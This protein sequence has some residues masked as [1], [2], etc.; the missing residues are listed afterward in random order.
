KISID[1]ASDFLNLNPDSSYN[2]DT[3]AEIN[4]EGCSENL[5]YSVS[6]TIEMEDP[7][8]HGN[9]ILSNN[10]ITGEARA[11]DY[12][13]YLSACISDDN[14]VVFPFT[15]KASIPNIDGNDVELFTDHYEVNGVSYTD[16][17]YY[18]F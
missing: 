8:I 13:E 2:L 12:T 17:T 1:N 16:N 14:C 6:S 15:K 9:S 10:L 5:N 18:N 4:K 7:S 3:L 11:S